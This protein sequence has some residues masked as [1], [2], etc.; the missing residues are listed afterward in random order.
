MKRTELLV[1]AARLV[2]LLIVWVCV[3]GM[4][5]AFDGLW[6]VVV[7]T[8]LVGSIWVFVV[9]PYLE[10]LIRAKQPRA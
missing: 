7:A 9:D 5:A 10:R 2:G 3:W 8:L 1:A 4:D 6:P